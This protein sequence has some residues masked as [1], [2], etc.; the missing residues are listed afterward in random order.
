MAMTVD[1]K[2][3]ETSDNGYLANAE[4]WTENIAHALAA[5]DGLTLTD[6]HMDVINFLRDEYLNNAGNCPNTRHMV[7]AMQER[8]GDNK[9]DTKTLYDLFPGNP[10]K[11]AGKIAGLPESKRKGGY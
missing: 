9:V 10:S 5:A 7:K 4:E 8:W 3:I 6:K 1:G 11:Q 2:S